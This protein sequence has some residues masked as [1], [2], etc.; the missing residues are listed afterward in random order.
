MLGAM[1]RKELRPTVIPELER[2]DAL[3]FDYRILH[4][5][6][7]NTSHMDIQEDREE[8][9]DLHKEKNADRNH[10]GKDRP[11]LVMTFSK[12]WFVDVC[13]FPKRS[14]FTLTKPDTAGKMNK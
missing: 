13:N 2:G 12:S 4:R 1:A 6:K 7:A 3:I 14:I 9:N 5:G 11:I 8:N 10:G